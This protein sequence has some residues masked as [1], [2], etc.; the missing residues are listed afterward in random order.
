MRAAVT[1][2]ARSLACNINH[3]ATMQ[4][5]VAGG[6]FLPWPRVVIFCVTPREFLRVATRTAQRG[7]YTPC[8]V[9]HG[10]HTPLHFLPLSSYLVGRRCN[11][12]TG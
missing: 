12:N 10:G 4:R 6:A 2:L 9:S 8:K 1:L 3:L 11:K 5:P 7:P